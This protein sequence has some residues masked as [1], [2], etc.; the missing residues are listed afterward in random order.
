MDAVNPIYTTI[1]TFPRKHPNCCTITELIKTCQYLGLDTQG[2]NKQELKAI[3]APCWIT[4]TVICNPPHRIEMVFQKQ[5]YYVNSSM[6][7]C[8]SFCKI[9]DNNTREI[10]K[11][12]RDRGSHT[13]NYNKITKEWKMYNKLNRRMLLTMNMK[14][15]NRLRQCIFYLEFEH[16]YKYSLLMCK[17]D[18]LISDIAQ[19]I[20]NVYF[21]Y[22]SLPPIVYKVL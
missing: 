12:E 5:L 20:R 17:N 18:I 11:I 14:E 9:Y 13:A 19:C 7:Y 2:K 6:I 21:D 8:D 22:L 15:I 1:F 16:V 3:L 4:S 10:Y